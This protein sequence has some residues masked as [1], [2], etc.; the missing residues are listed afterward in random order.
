MINDLI[1]NK[2][3]YMIVKKRPYLIILFTITIFAILTSLLYSL[4]DKVKIKAL[5]SCNEELCTLNFYQS[6]DSPYNINKIKIND[7]E[8]L[9][10][11]IFYGELETDNDNNYFQKISIIPNDYDLKNNEIVK[12][13]LINEKISL[14]K[15]V[16]KKVKEK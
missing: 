11:D 1:Y 6:Y 3:N 8:Y 2:Y 12:L 5:T 16:I 10:K 4:E 9:I 7:K 13:D 14:L 15:L